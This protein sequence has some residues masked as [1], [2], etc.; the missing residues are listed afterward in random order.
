MVLNTVLVKSQAGARDVAHLAAWS[1]SEQKPSR[2][3]LIVPAGTQGYWGSKRRRPS[4]YSA[5]SPEGL[6]KPHV[7]VIFGGSCV[8]G[9]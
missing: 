3:K 7:P 5:F 8:G 2:E 4:A 6:P 1:I 9:V